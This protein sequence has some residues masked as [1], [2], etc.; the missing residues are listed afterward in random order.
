MINRYQ[1]FFPKQKTAFEEKMAFKDLFEI[2]QELDKLG[3]K[4]WYIYDAREK[5]IIIRDAAVNVFKKLGYK[6]EQ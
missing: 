2:C 5:K 6:Y 3:R 1:L 4:D